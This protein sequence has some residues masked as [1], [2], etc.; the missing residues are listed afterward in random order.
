MTPLELSNLATLAETQNKSSDEVIR[1]LSDFNEKLAAMKVGVEL[2][3]DCLSFRTKGT[4]GYQIGY[5]KVEEGR[6]SAWMVAWRE[7]D[8]EKITDTFDGTSTWYSEDG[9]EEEAR[10]VLNAPRYVKFQ[11]L[12]QLPTLV[13]ELEQAIRVNLRAVETAKASLA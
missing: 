8:M 5:A 12:D 1:I 9:T 13:N 2:W 4:R 7:C 6:T 10:T 11:V 3:P